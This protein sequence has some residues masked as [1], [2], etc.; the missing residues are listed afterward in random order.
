MK[1]KIQSVQA[2]IK[3]AEAHFVCGTAAAPFGSLFL[4]S[5]FLMIPPVSCRDILAHI[6]VWP[7]EAWHRSAQGLTAPSRTLSLCCR[8]EQE[9]ALLQSY[10]PRTYVLNTSHL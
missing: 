10:F 3:S 1:G 2:R 4:K 8:E 5:R 9:S 7:D 6:R